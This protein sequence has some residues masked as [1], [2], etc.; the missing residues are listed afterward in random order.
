MKGFFIDMMINKRLIGLA[1]KSMRYVRLNVLL[2]WVSL[3]CNIVIVFSIGYLVESLISGAVDAARAVTSISVA[4]AG[5]AVRFACAL[6]V[7]KASFLAADEVKF[8]L[9]E[10]I[11]KK[12]LAL[13]PSYRDR[14]ATSK[15]LQVATEGVDQLETYFSKYLPQ[16]AYSLLAPVTLFAAL[17]FV[18]MPVAVALLLCVPLIPLS[19]VLVQRIAKKLLKQYWGSYTDLGEGFLENIQGLTTLKIYQA[20]ARKAAEMDAQAEGFRK[21]TMRVLTMQLNSITLMDLIAYGG[22]VVGIVLAVNGYIGGAVGFAGCFAIILLASEFFLPLRLLGS[23]FH[24]AMNGMAAS[25][26]IFKLL[27]LPDPQTGEIENASFDGDIQFE[28]VGFSY[29]GE[30]QAIRNIDLCLKPGITALVGE[31]G[32]GKSTVAALL[33]GRIRPASGTV[34]IDGRPV[35]AYTPRWLAQTITYLGHDSHLFTGTV[36]D[37]LRI[38]DS[39]VSDGRMWELLG[40][41][42]L[43]GFLREQQ[44]L[45]TRLEERAAN[46]SGGQRQRLALARAILHDSPVYIFDEATSN[47]DV[48]SENDITSIIWELGK[49][50]TVLFISHRLANVIPAGQIHVMDAGEVIESGSHG[51]LIAQKGRYAQLFNAQRTLENITKKEV[52]SA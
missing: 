33:A 24:I 40:K 20:D 1:K 37:N 49:S 27:D 32:C 31:S 2:Q 9:R 36:R 3:V 22:A 28:A 45:D 13:G 51:L 18:S 12:M 8:T 46:L 42:N 25:D 16:L 43:A 11:Y 52:L 30:R 5:I 38:A 29:D 47:I 48:E 19:I 17:S 44:G 23:F 21:I 10:A 4:V 41:V 34:S 14:V 39:S 26:K 7:A 50:K 6:G 35:A 15:I